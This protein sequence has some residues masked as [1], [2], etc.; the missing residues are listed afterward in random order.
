MGGLAAPFFWPLGND[1][2]AIVGGRVSHF[3]HIKCDLT[4]PPSSE[5]IGRRT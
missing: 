1:H 3:M 2:R 4:P 5:T